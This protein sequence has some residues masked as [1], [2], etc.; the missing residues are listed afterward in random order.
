MQ[1]QE[2]SRSDWPEQSAPPPPPLPTTTTIA[3]F[4]ADFAR[5]TPTTGW[6]YLWNNAG[7]IGNPANYTNLLISTTNAATGYIATPATYPATNAAEWAQVSGNGYVHPGTGTAQG[8]SGGIQRYTIAAFTLP[9]S[10][11]VSIINGSL[12]DDDLF[13]APPNDGINLL[14]HV[15]SAAAAFTRTI[16]NQ[17]STTFGPIDLGNLAAGARIYVAVGS[18]GP[19]GRNTSSGDSARLSFQIQQTR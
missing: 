17:G 2:R 5:P 14:I 19:E 6:A 11:A 18:H 1:R 4:V 9:L 13:V 3:D 12:R 8:A 16:P 15:D 10:G 7:P